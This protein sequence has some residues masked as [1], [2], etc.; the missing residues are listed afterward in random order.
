MCICLR[1]CSDNYRERITTSSG[2]V[3]GGFDVPH[4]HDVTTG[5]VLVDVNG[6]LR[7]RDSKNL[8]ILELLKILIKPVCRSFMV[9]VVIIGSKPFTGQFINQFNSIIFISIAIYP[10]PNQ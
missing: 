1:F 2:E 3:I 8:F 4:E 5:R 9:L 10:R 7:Q 6:A